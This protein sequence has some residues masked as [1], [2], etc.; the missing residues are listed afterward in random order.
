[1]ARAQYV[2]QPVNGIFNQVL[3]RDT[4]LLCMWEII[5]YVGNYYLRA[6]YVVQP[7][8]GICNQVLVRD[9]S[10]L[11]MWEIVLK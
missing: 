2:V 7:V 9:T 4:S 10:L 3:V 6:G 11:C 5:I 8:N 1:V